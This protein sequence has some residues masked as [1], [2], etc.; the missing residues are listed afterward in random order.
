MASLELYFLAAHIA[1]AMGSQKPT[2]S[3]NTVLY[4]NSGPSG[5]SHVRVDIV[6]LVL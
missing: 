4:H 3:E 5:L 1:G 6:S 2:G